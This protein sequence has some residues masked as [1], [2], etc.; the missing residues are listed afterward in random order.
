ME[1]WQTALRLK[2]GL[3]KRTVRFDYEWKA[4]LLAYDLC[5]VGPDEFAKLDLD[6]QINA[7]SYGAA[8]W[9]QMK[10]GKTV[11]FNYEELSKALLKASKADNQKLIDAM[12]YA[13]FPKWLQDGT[14]EVTK[15]NE[16][17]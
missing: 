3:F 9:H 14:P 4:W 13:K 1:K 17:P 6:K 10:K 11:R 2:I 7:L 5:G 16:N 8:Q 12:S 15:K